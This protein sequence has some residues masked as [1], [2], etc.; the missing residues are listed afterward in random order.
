M[1]NPAYIQKAERTAM[2]AGMEKGWAQGIY[3]PAPLQDARALMERYGCV[4][5]GAFLRKQP[6]KDPRVCV[7]YKPT[8]NPWCKNKTFESEDLC[9]V[10]KWGEPL[11]KMWSKDAENAF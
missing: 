8:L 7:N 1:C 11:M 5:S 10:S 9:D 2:R 4:I 3:A 6:G